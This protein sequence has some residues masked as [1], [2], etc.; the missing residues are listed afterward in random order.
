M[1]TETTVTLVG[2][3]G[4]KWT[5]S[6]PLSLIM[7]DQVERGSLRP[8]DA[9]SEA[10]LVDYLDEDVDADLDDEDEEVEVTEEAEALADEL[11]IDLDD[12]ADATDSDPITEE[13][14][15][16][17]ADAERGDGDDRTSEADDAE[18]DTPDYSKLK[19]PQLKALLDERGIEYPG[20]VVANAKLVELLEA[21]DADE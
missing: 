20:G 11:G 16:A 8:A 12:V 1:A 2:E 19:Q 17:F 7:R 6:L 5:F 10:L 15:Q 13:D 9:E 3:G 4:V 21:D 14:V 18:D